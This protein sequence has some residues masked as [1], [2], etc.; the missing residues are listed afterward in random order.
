MVQSS[1][2][3][4]I[5]S[6]NQ[7]TAQLTN[8]LDK[9]CETSALRRA[10]LCILSPDLPDSRLLLHSGDHVPGGLEPIYD[11]ASLTKP[12]FTT[13]MT[14]NQHSRGTMN[15]WDPLPFY[16]ETAPSSE[17]ITWAHVLAHSSG[18][19]WWRPLFAQFLNHIGGLS[20][21]KYY[22]RSE[23][24][25]IYREYLQRITPFCPPGTLQEYSDI[26]FL[27]LGY[28]LETVL[29]RSIDEI[30]KYYKRSFGL[31]DCFA[32]ESFPDNQSFVANLTQ[33][34]KGSSVASWLH[35]TIPTEIPLWRAEP[36]LGEPSD[37]NAFFA[38]GLGGHAGIFGSP[39]ELL[40]IAD[41]WIHALK[42]N[43]FDIDPVYLLDPVKLWNRI[44]RVKINQPTRTIGWD[45]PSGSAPCIGKE[46]GRKN[47]WIGHMGFSG[48]S[49]WIHPASSFAIGLLT[50]RIYPSRFSEKSRAFSGV[51]S[52]FHDEIRDILHS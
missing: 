14:L 43:S 15:I 25:K 42:S 6:P 23:V 11:W 9:L 12:L 2:R 28:S 35:R 44:A 33:S 36:L 41:I 27:S 32:P 1:F 48:A 8:A 26:G 45:T 38:R 24:G 37:E 4:H 19:P 20:R 49:I 52:R 34:L 50:H 3:V 21:W 39:S 17:S 47:G 16:A 22:S 46:W 13:L 7:K 18:L 51:R 5:R 30:F 31:L 10:S 40:K 29:G